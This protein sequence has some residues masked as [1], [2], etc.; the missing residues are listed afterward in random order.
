MELRQA[1]AKRGDI[2]EDKILTDYEEALQVA[3]A[4]AKPSSIVQAA[5]AQAKLVGLLK[6][7]IET[8]NVHDFETMES[9]DDIFRKV[10]DDLG[11]E[12][13]AALS[14]VFGLDK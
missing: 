6:D 4:Q 9:I 7:R 2:T 10:A 13:A 3:K 8:T 5:T 1:L 12:A 14:K 11:P